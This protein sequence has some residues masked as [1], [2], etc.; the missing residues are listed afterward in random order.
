MDLGIKGRSALVCASSQGL[1]LACAEALARE[2]VAVTLNGRRADT[3]AAAADALRHRVPGATVDCIAADLTT[4]D[5]RETIVRAKPEIDI[6]VNNNAG[7]AP[8]ALDQWDESALLG[9]LNAN[10]IPAVQLMRHYIP[11]MRARRFGRI[12]NITSAMVKSP[13]YIMG[14]ST[15]AR[16]ALTA[17]SKAISVE[18][19]VDNVTINNLLPERIDTP[20]Q[21]FMAQRL[22]SEHGIDRDEARRRIASTINAKRLGRP[23]EFGAACAFLCGVQASYISGQNLQLDGGSYEGLV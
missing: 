3:L 18:V 10:M 20:R 4:A 16:T 13:H 14:L 5:G 1:G 2:G 9:A 17:I 23:D 21:D 6:L 15:S 8:G 22:M 19:V 12:V 7:P 11:G